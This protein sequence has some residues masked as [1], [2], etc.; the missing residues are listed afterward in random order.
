MLTVAA[1]VAKGELMPDAFS[2][3]GAGD[4]QPDVR[5]LDA[6]EILFRDLATTSGPGGEVRKLHVEQRAL[7]A[8]HAEVEAD[9][10]VVITEFTRQY[11]HRH[12]PAPQVIRSATE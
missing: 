11:L 7:E 8:V 3:L 1:R 10:V 12:V 9:V 4:G 5:E 6:G 2:V